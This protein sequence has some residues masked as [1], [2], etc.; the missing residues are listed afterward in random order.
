MNMNLLEH[1]K[2][3][4]ADR[5]TVERE[6]GHGGMAVVFLAHDLKHDRR[7]AL[8]VLRPEIAAD[9]GTA[10]FLREIQTAAQLSHP[11]ILPLYDSG[12]ADGKLYYVMPYVD[13]ESL[14]DRLAAEHQLPIEE[15]IQITREVAAALSYAHSMGVVHRDVKPQ[16]ILL[17]GESAVVADFGIARAVR[18]AGGVKLTRT[19]MVVGTPVYMSPEQAGGGDVDGRADVYSLGCVLYE[20]LAGEPPFTAHTPEALIARHMLDPVSRPRILRQAIPEALEEVILKALE[21]SP[22]DRF[23]SAWDFSEALKKASGVPTRSGKALRFGRR[24]RWTAMRK[25]VWLA[26]LAVAVVATSWGAWQLTRGSPPTI[27]SGSGLDRRGVAVLYLRD[28]TPGGGNR[29]IA[30]GLTEGL[31]TQLSRV[32]PLSVIS[33]NGSAL[34]RDSDIAPDSIAR[35][36]NVASLVVGSVQ[37]AA[38]RIAV[39][40][41]LVDGASGVDYD[42]KRFEVPAERVLMLQDSLVGQ[43]EQW[44]RT[45]LGI[46]MQRRETRAAAHEVEAWVAYQQGSGARRN[47]DALLAVNDVEGAWYEYVR[48]DS[49]LAEAEM[50]DPVWPEPATLRSEIAYWQARLSIGDIRRADSIIEVALSHAERALGIDEAYPPALEMR[51]TL[52][53][54]RYLLGLTPPGQDAAELLG[55]AEGD[56][57]SAVTKDP[58]LASAYATLSH[59]YS[60]R[61]DWVEINLAAQRAYEADAYL[62]VADAVLYRLFS[63]SYDLQHHVN[64]VRWC[65]ELGR[66]FPEDPLAV[67]CQLYLMTS[68]AR[69]P[70]PF[71]AWR[72]VDEIVNRTPEP[73]RALTQLDGHIMVA[74]VLARAGQRDS[75]V[76]VLARSSVDP[77]IDPTLD[78]LPKVAFVHTLLGEHDEAIS[79]LR[80]YFAANPG[81]EFREGDNISWWWKDIVDDPRF[82]ELMTERN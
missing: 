32:Q 47:A 62:R 65:D 55:E 24:S 51:G 76:N 68:E 72:L 42:R 40:V 60:Q 16:N 75:A 13:G 33:R 39:A 35:A 46:E 43:V 26:A 57:R 34:Y 82:R 74:A 2:A 56:L 67:E 30:D 22:A 6:L 54:L 21:K 19:G 25:A 48:A 71:Q 79:I 11:H 44:L 8:K 36:L 45:R 27:D 78:L 41:Q 10:R 50:R 53:Y 64:S 9:L 49:L 5:Y 1:L 77:E 12:D 20:M 38:D 73:L 69:D 80:R 29:H 52:R 66:R 58:E 31:I 70:D 14:A 15:A 4:L 23:K 3:A 18:E 59:L 17:S 7:V 61:G 37:P 28:R 63:S 81:H